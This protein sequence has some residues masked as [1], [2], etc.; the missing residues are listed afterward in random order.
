MKLLLFC[1]KCVSPNLRIS[2]SARSVVIN[3]QLHYASGYEEI[4]ECPNC[5]YLGIECIEADSSYLKIREENKAHALIKKE[6]MKKFEQEKIAEQ[7]LIN[8]Q[9]MLNQLNEVS[10]EVK[11]EQLPQLNQAQ[12]PEIVQ[13]KLIQESKE[14]LEAKIQ[15]SNQAKNEQPMQ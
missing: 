7:Q 8:Q 10:I 11:T 13:Q 9:E 6:K 1:P 4:Y 5:K 2:L 15:A 14:I 12:E 3:D